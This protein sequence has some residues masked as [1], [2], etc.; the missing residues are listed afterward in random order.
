MYLRALSIEVIHRL[1]T[2]LSTYCTIQPL[3]DTHTHTQH[4]IVGQYS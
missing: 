1:F 2:Q 4:Y 3:A